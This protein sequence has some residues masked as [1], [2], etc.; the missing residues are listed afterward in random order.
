LG[1][2]EDI[3]GRP[4][5]DS[6]NEDLSWEPEESGIEE[7]TLD[8]FNVDCQL[9]NDFLLFEFSLDSIDPETRQKGLEI[10]ANKFYHRNLYGNIQIQYRKSRKENANENIETHAQR[11]IARIHRFN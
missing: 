8:D 10:A 1:I 5:T 2:F 9:I 4:H 11:V 6:D 3:L 7:L